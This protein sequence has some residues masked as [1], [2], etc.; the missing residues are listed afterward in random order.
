VAGILNQFSPG[1]FEPIVLGAERGMKT[2]RAAIT[3]PEVT[4]APFGDQPRNAIA[5]IGAARCDV[6]YHWEVGTDSLN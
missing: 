1:R 5:R 6:L 3:N 4:F 2:L